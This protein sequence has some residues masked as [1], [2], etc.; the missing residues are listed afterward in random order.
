MPSLSIHGQ[1]LPAV[2]AFDWLGALRAR[3]SEP[4]PG[5]WAQARFE[6]ELGFG[7]HFGPASPDARPAAVVA[8]LY[9]RDGQWHVPLTTRPATMLTHAGQIS[10]PGGGID[11]GEST[12]AAVLR[13]LSEELGIS[14]IGVELIGQ[15]SPLYLYNSN[16]RVTAWLA[17]ALERPAFAPDPREVAELLE[18]PLAHLIDPRH[19]GEHARRTRGIGLRAPHIAWGRHRIW[20]ATSMILGELI[21]LIEDILPMNEQANLP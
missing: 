9:P 8:L 14:P 2:D 17:A 6:P 20:G 19:H 3:M 10:F 16:H 11:P 18:V 12:D 13:E 21:A 15:L 5:R 7:R 1:T 4:L